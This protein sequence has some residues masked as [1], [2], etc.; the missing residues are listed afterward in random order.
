MRTTDHV[1]LML[2]GA[3]I[4]MAVV[5]CSSALFA[6]LLGRGAGLAIAETGLIWRRAAGRDGLPAVQERGGSTRPRT[7]A[8]PGRR[9]GMLNARPSGDGIEP[10]TPT[11][12]SPALANACTPWLELPL[13]NLRFPAG[14]LQVLPLLK[15]G[16]RQCPRRSS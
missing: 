16:G 4:G 11:Q 6:A 2:G 9:S 5:R 7:R 8:P 10:A 14:M 1:A 13:R 3:V 12:L 15:A